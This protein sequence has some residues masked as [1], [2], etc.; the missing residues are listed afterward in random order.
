[1]S[2]SSAH[3]KVTRPSKSGLGGGDW[4]S[5]NFIADLFV[6]GSRDDEF[7]GAFTAIRQR[8][9]AAIAPFLNTPDHAAIELEVEKCRQVTRG[10]SGAAA[11]SEGGQVGAGIIPGNIA[12]IMQN[13]SAMSGASISAFK[14]RFVGQLGPAIGG[15]HGISLVVGS[16]L[17]AEKGMWQAAREDVVEIVTSARDASR[18]LSDSGTTVSWSYPLKVAG[19]A[20][21]G[22]G[23]FF[24]G[25]KPAL[26][27]VGLGIQVVAGTIAEHEPA[28]ISGADALAV[29]ASFE[30]SLERLNEAIAAEE[31]L[32][33]ANIVQNLANIRADTA[34]YDLSV[35]PIVNDD[36]G[37]VIAYTPGLIDEITDTYMPAISGELASIANIIYLVNVGT[38][39]RYGELGMGWRGPG[40][41]WRELRR[42]LWELLK[43]LAWEVERGAENLHLVLL[44][45]QGHEDATARDL[46]LVFSELQN[47]SPYD[48]WD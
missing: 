35:P 14:S 41:S 39:E 1:M 37:D 34:S 5:D 28:E 32:L 31:R 4:S 30:Q 20:A 25:A 33:E 22:A 40:E 8:I 19:W 36:A 24:P 44:E 21:K 3:Y 12:L 29:L 6:G 11:A 45:L 26:E 15:L 9:D 17:A 13:S 46:Q 38:L 10:L 48:P 42:M 2:S 16:V 23:M 27:V 47:G 7:T 18:S 43:D